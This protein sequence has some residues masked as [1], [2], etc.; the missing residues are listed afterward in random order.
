MWLSPSALVAFVDK[1]A[2]VDTDLH[3][4]ALNCR[5]VRPKSV[6]RNATFLRVRD[7]GNGKSEEKKK[8][9]FIEPRWGLKDTP[10][11]PR[12]LTCNL[13]RCAGQRTRKRLSGTEGMSATL[14]RMICF[15]TM[16]WRSTWRRHQVKKPN[17]PTVKVLN[18]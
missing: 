9:L 13:M 3:K 2:I 7:Y 15:L 6:A 12:H 5:K 18:D 10:G 11:Y 17:R 16:P 8:G 4:I 14:R 1:L